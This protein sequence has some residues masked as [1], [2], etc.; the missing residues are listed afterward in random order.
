M[1]WCMHAGGPCVFSNWEGLLSQDCTSFNQSHVV[2]ACAAALLGFK[3]VLCV[4]ICAACELRCQTLIFVAKSFIY[5]R[6]WWFWLFLWVVQDIWLFHFCVLWVQAVL[7]N[8][9]NVSVAAALCLVSICSLVDVNLG[10]K[11]FKP[12]WVFQSLWS[13]DFWGGSFDNSDGP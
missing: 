13:K 1:S 2:L 3:K 4:V 12:V 9:M 7:V 11:L 8:V 6:I 5:G 10:C